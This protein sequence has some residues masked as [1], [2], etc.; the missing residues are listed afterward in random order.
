MGAGKKKGRN[1]SIPGS[2]IGAF[3]QRIAGGKIYISGRPQSRDGKIPW[4]E[5]K[6][7]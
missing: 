3:K 5:E 4:R 1:P 7:R 2:L 6:G